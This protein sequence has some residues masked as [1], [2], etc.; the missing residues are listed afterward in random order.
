[1]IKATITVDCK[2]W[3]VPNFICT[4]SPEVPI[5]IENAPRE[6]VKE[7]LSEFTKNVWAKYNT[8]KAKE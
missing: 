5:P 2:P 8:P 1:M 3:T 7:M 4:I 6:L